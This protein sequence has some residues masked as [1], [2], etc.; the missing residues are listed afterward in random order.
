M[1]SVHLDIG[2]VTLYHTLFVYLGTETISSLFYFV[3]KVLGVKLNMVLI[4]VI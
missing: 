2:D 4:A 1:R 3:S